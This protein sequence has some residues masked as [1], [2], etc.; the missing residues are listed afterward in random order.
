MAEEWKAMS[1]KEKEPYNLMS[2]LDR[3][4]RDKEV[5]EYKRSIELDKDR[6][7]DEARKQ[8]SGFFWFMGQ[9]RKALKEKYPAMS[10]T[11]LTFVI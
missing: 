6:Y 1:E 11:E 8:S 9:R 3:Q 2:Q 10:S 5:L 7:I 4:R